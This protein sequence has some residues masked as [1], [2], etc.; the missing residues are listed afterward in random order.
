MSIFS[1][2]YLTILSVLVICVF[3]VNV[4]YAEPV[5][6]GSWTKQSQKI[7][8]SWA[9]VQKEDGYYVQLDEDF[10]TKSA[11]DLKLFLSK[12]QPDALN[13]KNATDGSAFLA[14]LD[15]TKGAQEYKIP[16]DVNIE[17]YGTIILHCQKFSKLWGASSL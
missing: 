17:E 1:K 8:G 2:F 11:P 4:S 5:A 10:K 9:I 6:S 7:K 13:G 14:K 15:S 16:E 3:A 12:K